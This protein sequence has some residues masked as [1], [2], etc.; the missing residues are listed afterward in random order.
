[1]KYKHTLAPEKLPR[2]VQLLTPHDN[3]LLT[4]KK[5]LGNGGSQTPKEMSLAIDDNLPTHELSH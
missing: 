3:D 4:V 1:M 2:N 5:L